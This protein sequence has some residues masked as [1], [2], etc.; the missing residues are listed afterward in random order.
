MGRRVCGKLQ[1]R[2]RVVM[3]R[4]FAY[5]EVDRGLDGA[6]DTP[7]LQLLAQRFKLVEEGKTIVPSALCW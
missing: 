2:I 6:E 4:I 1:G 7:F 5:L 3:R